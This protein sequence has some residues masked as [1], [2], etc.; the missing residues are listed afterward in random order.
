[1]D[2]F[3]KILA[4]VWIG[5]LISMGVITMIEKGIEPGC[6]KVQPGLFIERAEVWEK[7]GN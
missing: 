1:M 2:D 4:G 7:E 3:G 5:L 6:V